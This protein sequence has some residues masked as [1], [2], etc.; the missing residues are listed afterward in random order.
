MSVADNLNT[1]LQQIRD[2]ESK[3]NRPADSVQLL[4]VSKRHSAEKIIEAYQAGQHV[5]AENYLQE[6]LY[7]IQ[8]L[9]EYDIEWHFIGS[10]QSNKTRKIAENFA[11]VHSVSRFKIA[12]RLSQQRPSDLADLNICIEVNI[13]AESSKSGVMPDELLPL[14]IQIAQ[15]PHI[16]LRGLMVIPKFYETHEEQLAAF[17]R[18]ANLLDDLNQHGLQ[19][20][21]LSMGMS[22][23][24]PAAIAAGSTMVRI[25]TAIFGA[26][27]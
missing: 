12:E 15:L 24:F 5:F 17:Q 16:K 10:I 2:A 11:W 8:Q 14:A 7:K 3:A 27:K 9:Q 13:D 18:A 25:G 22:A 20:D 6:A 4:A 26:R 1:V 21:T 23:D 19:L